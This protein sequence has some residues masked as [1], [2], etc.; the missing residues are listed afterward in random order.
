MEYDKQL[1]ELFDS[2]YE[3]LFEKEVALGLR[4]HSSTT[5]FTERELIEAFGVSRN[6]LYRA[7]K[8]GDLPYQYQS[9]G[10]IRYSYD[11]ILLALKT[12]RFRLA[13]KTKA[14]AIEQLTEYRNMKE[15]SYGGQY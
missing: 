4:P 6:T 5:S 13:K 11:T 3:F 8:N 15:M 1:R 12:N 9:N 10:T 2:I 7:R 14:E